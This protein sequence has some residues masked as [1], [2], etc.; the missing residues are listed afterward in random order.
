MTTE[1]SAETIA[2]ARRAAKPYEAPGQT[3]NVRTKRVP[4]QGANP[5]DVWAIPNTGYRG[6]HFAT[7]PL[8]LPTR[9]IA[10]GCKPG[11]AVLDP[12]CGSGTT[13]AAALDLGRTFIGIELNA[14]YC[15]LT[16]DRLSPRNPS[17][18]VP[19]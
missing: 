7:F 11:G 14:D 3:P 4:E 12:F 5:G 18:E 15:A 2:R 1:T 13:G 16:A 9:C 10:A 6:A 19:A 8:A 17:L